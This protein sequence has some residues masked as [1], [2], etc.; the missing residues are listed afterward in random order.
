MVLSSYDIVSMSLAGAMEKHPDWKENA[1]QMGTVK[2]ACSEAD[3]FF[4]AGDYDL[5]A[6]TDPNGSVWFVLKD[7]ATGDNIRRW[8]IK[9]VFTVE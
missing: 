4:K 1:D 8:I 9:E 3:Q 7:P 5:K 2:L 6:G